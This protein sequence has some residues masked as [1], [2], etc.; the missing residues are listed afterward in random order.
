MNRNLSRRRRRGAFTLLEVLLVLA[1]LVI[2]GSMVTVFFARTQQGAYEKAAKAQISAFEQAID[3]YRLH[4]GTYP[5]ASQ[6]LE[7][8]RV[9][10]ADLKNPAKWQ[11]PY[12]KDTIPA[13]PWD[14]PYQYELL[15]T[16]AMSLNPYKITSWGADGVE[17]T[18]DD[19]SNI[20]P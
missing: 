9:P 17:G 10:P 7:S 13:D 6:G 8:L 2:L 18:E 12:I 4:V 14:N 15:D 1:I 19:I 16:S 3:L 5:S 11:G 20:T